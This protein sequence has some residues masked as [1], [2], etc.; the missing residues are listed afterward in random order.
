[1]GILP[2]IP[3]ECEASTRYSEGLYENESISHL[4]PRR[5]KKSSKKLKIKIKIKYDQ[6]D[7]Y[8]TVT[9]L[10]THYQSGF[11]SLHN[12]LVH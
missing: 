11:R 6:L 7:E 8:F 2:F 4:N 9:N 3:V 10:L 5:H 12:Y 1:M